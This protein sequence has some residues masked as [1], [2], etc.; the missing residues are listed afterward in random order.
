MSFGE[1]DLKADEKNA[2]TQ[3]VRAHNLMRTTISGGVIYIN[4]IY[5]SG[6]KRRWNTAH[7][8]LR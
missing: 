6:G 8:S 4:I 7:N 1:T 2:T 5:I 3:V